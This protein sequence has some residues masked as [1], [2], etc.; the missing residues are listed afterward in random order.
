MNKSDKNL[1]YDVEQRVFFI[2]G[3]IEKDL[4]G[5]ICFE[6]TKL[7]NQDNEKEKTHKDFTRKP[8]H[9]HINSVG[10]TIYD[11]WRLVSLI[12]SSKTPIYTY[13]T[14]YAFSMGFVI[15]I[16]GHRRYMSQ[17]GML[18]YHQISG[19]QIGKYLDIVQGTKNYER[20]QNKIE[21]FIKSKTKI[22][23][24][25]LDEIKE[26]KIDWYIDAEEAISLCIAEELI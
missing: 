7:I 23:Q 5:E 3:E 6:L 21:Q 4:I 14:G 19:G 25:K 13:C 11:G 22:S 12:E 24:N 2:N 26:K 9:I 17:F 1:F 8:I 16:A 20:N 15:F 18:M 10:G